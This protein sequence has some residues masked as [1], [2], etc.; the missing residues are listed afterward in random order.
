VVVLTA[1]SQTQRHQRAR[2]PGRVSQ[3]TVRYHR[4][5]WRR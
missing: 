4:Y 2:R 1:L 3:R 5:R